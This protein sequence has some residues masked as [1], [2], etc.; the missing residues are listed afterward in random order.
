MKTTET[1]KGFPYLLLYYGNQKLPTRKIQYI[2]GEGN[3]SFIKTTLNE[4]LTS[5]F[6]LK[7]VFREIIASRKF[8]LTSQRFAFAH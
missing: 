2:E 8:L 6:T 5:A 4:V 1:S 7:T 3:Y